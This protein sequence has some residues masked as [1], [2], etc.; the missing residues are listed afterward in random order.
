MPKQ[1]LVQELKSICDLPGHIAKA[2]Q[3][4]LLY[5]DV[6]IALHLSALESQLAISDPEPKRDQ[7]AGLQKPCCLHIG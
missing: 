7:S 4:E 6:A 3:A 5:A 1:A 2:S